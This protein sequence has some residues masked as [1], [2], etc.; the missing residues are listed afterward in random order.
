M[1]YILTDIMQKAKKNPACGRQAAKKM[2][3]WHYFLFLA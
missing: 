3:E 2:R 1:L